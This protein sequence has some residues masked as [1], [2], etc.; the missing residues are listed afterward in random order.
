MLEIR[1]KQQYTDFVQE[2]K[3]YMIH[4]KYMKRM[5]PLKISS[6]CKQIQNCAAQ[7]VRFFV[8]DSF[9]KCEQFGRKLRFCS[10][11]LKKSLAKS[12]IVL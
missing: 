5:F 4:E 10:H 9:S 6:I 1:A 11:L 12:V 7:K 3:I 2:Y 8:K